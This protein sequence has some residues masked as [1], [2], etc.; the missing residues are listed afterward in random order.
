MD[1]AA[2]PAMPREGDGTAK[3]GISFAETGD[4]LMPDFVSA[5]IRRQVGASSF[6]PSPGRA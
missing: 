6:E 1:S 5:I 3:F 2:W 4:K